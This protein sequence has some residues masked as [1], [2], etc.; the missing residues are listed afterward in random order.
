[1]V[2][3][4][5]G[6]FIGRNGGGRVNRRRISAFGEFRRFWEVELFLMFGVWF[7]VRRVVGVG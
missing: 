7:W 6:G 4:F 2:G 3:G 1:M 5:I